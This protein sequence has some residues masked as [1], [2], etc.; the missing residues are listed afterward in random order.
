MA[1][2]DWNGNGN[3]NDM[4]DNYI[5]Y[6]IYKDFTD[7]NKLPKRAE[8]SSASGFWIVFLIALFVSVFNEGL[9]VLI[10]VGYGWLKF[11]GM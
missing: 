10:L 9:G 2:Y 4:V 3:R 5:E 7:N 8:S 1:M 11:M 6:R